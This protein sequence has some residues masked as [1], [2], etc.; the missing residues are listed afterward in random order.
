M[1]ETLRDAWDDLNQGRG[2][3]HGLFLPRV[4]YVAR[5]QKT[6]TSNP[7]GFQLLQKQTLGNLAHAESLL[8][9]EQTSEHAPGQK[10][11]STRVSCHL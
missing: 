3:K 1:T 4:L 8:Y 9:H 11:G 5:I 6:H 2:I 7:S 10:Q